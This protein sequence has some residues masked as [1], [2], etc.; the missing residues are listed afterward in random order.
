MT[1]EKISI[2]FAEMQFLWFLLHL[3]T[4]SNSWVQLVKVRVMQHT[5]HQKTVE[6][7][8]MRRIDLME[9]L[10]RVHSV[11]ATQRNCL[12]AKEEMGNL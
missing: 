8:N 3:P 6:E 12:P 7:T 1:S 11:I 9:G 4:R 5:V 10:R 2:I